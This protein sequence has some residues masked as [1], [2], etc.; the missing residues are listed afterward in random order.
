LSTLEHVRKELALERCQA[1]CERLW[2]LA[3][4]LRVRMR[5]LD[6]LL[7]ARGRGAWLDNAIASAE[8]DRRGYEE[9]IRQ[10]RETLRSQHVS[11]PH[12][13]R[14]EWPS[15]SSANLAKELVS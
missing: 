14:A 2:A 7:A 9:A 13:E 8:Q 3:P 10:L 11:C 5:K 12:F 6:S 1:E 4:D 15:R